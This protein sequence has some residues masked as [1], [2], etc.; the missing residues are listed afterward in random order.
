MLL[1]HIF[2]ISVF[3]LG[4]LFHLSVIHL[5]TILTNAD[6]FAYLQMSYFLK[7]GLLEGFGT[8]WFGFLYSA[9]VAFGN[10]FVENDFFA[11][12]IINLILFNI[13]GVILFFIGKRY[14][15][16]HY[17]IVLILIYFLSSALL[18]YNINILSENLFIPLFLLLFLF[19]QRIG[20]NSNFFNALMIGIICAFLYFTRSESFIYILSLGIIGLIFL[21]RKLLLGKEFIKYSMTIILSFFIIIAPYVY[22]LHTITGEWGLTN[23]GSSNIRQAMM[24][25]TE[26][27]DDEG[28]EKAVGELSSDN[29][30]LIAGFV[31]GLKYDKPSE[32][33]SISNFLLQ[34]KKSTLKRFLTNQKKLYSQTLPKMLLGDILKLYKD[35]GFIFYDNFLILIIIFIPLV[36]FILG[37]LNLLFKKNSLFMPIF[38]SLFLVGS[39]FFTLFFVLERYFIIFLP[40]MFLIMIYGAQEFLTSFEKFEVGKYIA[41]LGIFVFVYYM[42][43]LFFS[44]NLNNSKYEVKKVAGEW[45]QENIKGLGKKDPSELKIMERFPIMTYYAGTKERWLTPY[46]SKI[47]NLI[48]YAQ[49]NKIDLLV[50]DSLDFKTYRKDLSVL[51]NKDIKYQNLEFVKM[52]TLNGEKV[53]IYKFNY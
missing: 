21:K 17:N 14:L 6:S 4:S 27:M 32:N 41:S 8:G 49:Y 46:T 38:L 13:G 5:N 39:I 15:N 33:Y 1:P 53:L 23:K 35:P 37:G 50:V 40:L 12:Q 24:R 31:G 51:L 45:I 25:G 43:I 9:C 10:L 30:H 44:Q 7:N 36:F 22:Y 16:I 42:G 34:D 52:L 28:F 2:L 29:H 47:S 20:E 19:L 3:F 26:K 11:G 48:E 18:N